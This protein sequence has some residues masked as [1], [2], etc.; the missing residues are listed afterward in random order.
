MIFDAHVFPV[1]I[2]NGPQLASTEAITALMGEHEIDRVMLVS[3]D[4]D[5]LLGHVDAIDGA[6]AMPWI[7]PRVDGAVDRV[8]DLFGHPKVRG[9]KLNP[10]VDPLEPADPRLHPIYEL[11]A[12]HGVPV[13][14]HCGHPPASLYTQPFQIEKAAERFPQT[15]FIMVHMGLCVFDYHHAAMRAAERLPNVYLEVSRMP[16]DW[17]VKIAVERVGVERV[18]YGSAAPWYHPKLELMKVRTAGLTPDQTEAVLGGSASALFLGE[19]RSE[20]TA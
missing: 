17:Q 16:H 2:P 8:R 12:E 11:A 3:K 7:D 20:A 19:A 4:T 13:G 9:I 14:F 18:L 6:Y 15:I 1:D 5:A 10:A